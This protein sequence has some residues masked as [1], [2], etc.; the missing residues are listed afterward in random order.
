MNSGNGE[1]GLGYDY[2][3]CAICKLCRDERCFELAKYMCK[4]DFMFADIMGMR[5]ERTS[6]LA[7]GGKKCD[8]RFYRK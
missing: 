4:L 6:T 2:L 1:L 8:F 3:E 5:L 7:D